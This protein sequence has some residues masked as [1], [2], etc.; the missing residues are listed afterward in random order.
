MLFH[1]GFI[2]LP[3]SGDDDEITHA[4]TSRRAAVER[5]GAAA[6]LGANGI[7]AEAFA[8]VNVPDIDALEFAN[9]CRLE[10]VVI[11]GA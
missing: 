4:R 10:Q 2:K 11:N 6:V 3:K 9:A 7:S 8:I 1:F 5:N